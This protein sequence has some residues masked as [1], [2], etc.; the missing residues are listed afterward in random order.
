MRDR[1]EGDVAMSAGYFAEIE[2]SLFGEWT[3]A[4]AQEGDDERSGGEL[5]F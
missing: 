3:A 5:D 4:V 2:E 1:D